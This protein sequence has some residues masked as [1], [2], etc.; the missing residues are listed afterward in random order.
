[1]PY[2]ANFSGR[3]SVRSYSLVGVGQI[4]V[5][6]Q[7]GSRYL[8]TYPVTGKTMVDEMVRLAKAGAGLGSYITRRVRQSY[9]A[10]Y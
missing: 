4:E 10:K 7:D 3:S 6:F 8:Y 1:M 9:A 2:Y 5:T